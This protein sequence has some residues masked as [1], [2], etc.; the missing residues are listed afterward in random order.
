MNE[1]E[2]MLVQRKDLT[3]ILPVS[4]GTIQSFIR[5]GLADKAATGHG[6]GIRYD[7]R[8]VVEWYANYCIEQDTKNRPN[9]STYDK[10]AAEAELMH[11][12]KERQ[13]QI[14]LKEAGKLITIDESAAE[15]NY[16]L[17]QVQQILNVIPTKWSQFVLHLESIGEAQTVLGDCLETLKKSITAA[18]TT[19]EESTPEDDASEDV[20]VPDVDV[21]E[22]DDD[23]PI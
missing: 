12:K 16:R 22:S 7:V 1:Y 9:Q 13:H 6:A 17:I 23:L 21:E 18:L 14:V 3:S 4:A 2:P 5:T 10:D 15:L 20:I 8:K 19:P 11:W